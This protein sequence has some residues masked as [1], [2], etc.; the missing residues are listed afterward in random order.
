MIIA[1]GSCK[2]SPG[3]TTLALTLAMEWTSE[4][5]VLEADPSGGDLAFRTHRPGAEFLDPEPTTVTLAVDAR[6]RARSLNMARYAQ[7]TDLGVPVVPGAPGQ[8][9]WEPIAQLWP[10]V[11]ECLSEWP[12]TVI[13]DVGRLHSTH[14]GMALV[15]AADVLVLLAPSGVEGLFHVRDLASH[16]LDDA[17]SARPHQR[18]G[19]VIRAGSRGRD[20]MDQVARVVATMGIP[21][22]VVGGFAED[23]VG[24]EALAAGKDTVAL[25]RSALMR[26]SA[27]LVKRL[28]RTSG[29][30]RIDGV[31]GREVAAEGG[32]VAGVA[33]GAV[34]RARESLKLLKGER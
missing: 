29:S 30:A 26:S 13:V 19:V 14:P 15:R 17:D 2:G 7:H 16:L 32:R 24:V 1:I 23:P 8:Q 10:Q 11:A 4:R 34:R 9:A 21:V 25:R 33:D 28:Q 18:V 20:P 3:V 27:D 5:L 22:S 31:P 12:G 6:A